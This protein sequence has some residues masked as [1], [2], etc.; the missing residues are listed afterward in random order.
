[1]CRKKSQYQ[2]T[3]ALCPEQLLKYRMCCSLRK[4]ILPDPVELTQFHYELTCL[5]L[6]EPIDAMLDP[7]NVK[8]ELGGPCLWWPRFTWLQG[9]ILVERCEWLEMRMC[10]S[11]GLIYMY[12]SRIFDPFKKS[13][14]S[15]TYSFII[16]WIWIDFRAPKFEKTPKTS[17]TGLSVSVHWKWESQ[18]R[19]PQLH[20][21][22]SGDSRFSQK[23]V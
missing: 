12:I 10:K 22:A 1:M 5:E 3:C 2:L 6:F 14:N 7:W 18:D 16:N 20:L 9:K 8:T 13:G 15:T 19:S 23:K 4:G 21:K 17:S 11:Q